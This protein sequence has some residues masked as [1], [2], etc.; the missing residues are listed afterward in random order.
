MDSKTYTQFGTFTVIIMSAL[1]IVVASLLIKH[2]FSPDPETYLYAF[3]VLI[4]LICLLTFYKLTIIV[5][6]TTVSF[7]LGIGIFGKSYNTTEIASCKP[8][9]NLWIYGVGIHKI[10]NGWLYN[11]SGL[12]AIELRFKDSTRVIRIGTN[13]PDEIA[14]MINKLI[15]TEVESEDNT[16]EFKIKSKTKNTIILVAVVGVIIFCFNYYSSMPIKIDM[17]E[18]RF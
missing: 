5:D 15:G 10:P 11:V 7:K 2:G 4:S 9:K 16:P 17:K 3:L 12:K 6:D 13:K 8:V 18:A 14:G 1:L